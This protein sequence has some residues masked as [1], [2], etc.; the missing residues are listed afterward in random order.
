MAAHTQTADG[1]MRTRADRAQW[2]GVGRCASQVLY[3][4]TRERDDLVASKVLESKVD[5]AIAA[6]GLKEEL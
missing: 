1:R 4:K 3:F 5:A 2:P 6:M